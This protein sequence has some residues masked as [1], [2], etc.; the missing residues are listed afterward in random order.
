MPAWPP[1]PRR[2]PAAAS[3]TTSKPR[4]SAWS[5]MRAR[6]SAGR[7]RPRPHRVRAPPGGG[8]RSCRPH[9]RPQGADHRRPRRARQAAQRESRAD[10]ARHPKQSRGLLRE[11][12]GVRFAWIA[13]E[14]ATYPLRVLCRVLRVTASGFYAW[15]RRPVSAHARR[16]G[17]LVVRIRARLTKAR[18]RYGRPRIHDDLREGACPSVGSAWR[19]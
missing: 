14:R 11:A 4:P 9:R 16:D 1:R 17:E 19:V 3:M 15:Q 2:G 7:P 8:A 10:G 6:A 5:S 18:H 12:P 13:T